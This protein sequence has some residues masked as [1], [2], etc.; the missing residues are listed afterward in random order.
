[1]KK[2]VGIIRSLSQ[3]SRKPGRA[4]Q[5]AESRL[6]RETTREP[7][8]RR[9][10]DEQWQRDIATLRRAAQDLAQRRSEQGINPR[11]FADQFDRLAT[12]VIECTDQQRPSIIG[13]LYNLDPERAAS[14]INMVLHGGTREERQQIGAALEKSGLI[15]EAI[16]NLTASSHS[17]SYRAFSLLF[18]M[19]KAGTFGPLM[20]VIEDHPN[21]ELR[22]ALI[23][24]LGNSGAPDL[25][26]QFQRLLAKKSMPAELSAAIKEITVQGSG[27][28][29]DLTSS[30]A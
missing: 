5:P 24:L 27:K 6:S 14:F 30:A 4:Q 15:D 3:N 23:R 16:K 17:H 12:S 11:V 1:M 8:S 28:T 10:D 21:I 19:A 7:G 18:L 9:R 20:R 22:L 2:K 26:H 25:P 13:Q 29:V